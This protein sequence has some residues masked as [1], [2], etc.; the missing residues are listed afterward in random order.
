[1]KKSF[2]FPFGA[3]KGAAL[4]I[5]LALVVPGTLCNTECARAATDECV[6]VSSALVANGGNFYKVGDILD[7]LFGNL[8]GSANDY[9]FR[10]QVASVDDPSTGR[11][12]AVTM[13]A[14]IGYSNPPPNP[15]R[16][17]GS[18]TGTGVTANCTF[19]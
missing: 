6:N 12:T 2:H 9:G 5:V 14:G 18:A 4:I 7:P 17:G 15:I 10:L 11:V 19:N 1:M 16:L 3:S 13:I 8:C